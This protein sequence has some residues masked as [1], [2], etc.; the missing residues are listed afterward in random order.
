MT[1]SLLQYRYRSWRRTR[2]RLRTGDN[3]CNGSF[4]VSTHTLPAF[5]PRHEA[6]LVSFLIAARHILTCEAVN[7]RPLLTLPFS[8]LYHLHR[9]SNRLLLLYAHYRPI[10]RGCTPGPDPPNRAIPATLTPMVRC[11]LSRNSSTRDICNLPMRR[12]RTRRKRTRVDKE[13]CLGASWEVDRDRRLR[14]KGQ[15]KYTLVYT[16]A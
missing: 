4:Q 10:Y 7:L 8:L 15:L 13:M 1:W 9:V 11:R 2:Y 14:T 3:C 16:R 5:P 6:F 12:R